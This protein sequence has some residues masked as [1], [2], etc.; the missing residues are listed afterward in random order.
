MPPLTNWI[1]SRLERINPLPSAHFSPCLQPACRLAKPARNSVGGAMLAFALLGIGV[2]SA[3][4]AIP[5]ADLPAG[6]E[7]VIAAAPPLLNHPIMG[8]LDDRGR[9]FVGDAAGLNL[10]DKAL[11]EQLPNRV[12]M[13]E[14]TNGDGVFDKTSVFADK[15]TFPQGACWLNGSLYV[16]SPPGIW[17]LTDTNG[18][19]VA[20]ERKM[21]VSGFKYTG[22]AADVHGPFLHPNGRLYW[23]HGRKG[24]KVTQPDGTLVH[25]GM[26][27]GIWSCKP[28]G[29]DVQWH[30]LA[31]SDN[32]V[33]VDFTPEGDIF[34]VINIYY[35]RPRGDTLVHWLYGG[36]Y[37]RPDQLNVL[38]GL[39]RTVEK[40]PVVHNFGH[41]AVSGCSF[42]RS[43]GLNPA[44]KGDMMVVYFNTQ[45]IVR[46]NLKPS[47][48][49]FTAT[50]HE[51]LKIHDPDVHI[52]DLIEDVDGSILVID[53]GGWFKLG[54]PSS[55]MEKPDIRGAVYRVQKKNPP[56]RDIA[57]LRKAANAAKNSAYQPEFRMADLKDASKPLARLR[58]CEAI[59]RAKRIEPAQRD[60]LL[61]LLGEKVDPALE[62]AAMYAAITTRC[63]DLA[64]LRQAS[65]APL[66]RRLMLIVE[67]TAREIPVQDA[68]FAVA[69]SHVDS[70]D[71]D[72]ASAAA[73]LVARHPRGL[74]LAF[75]D[76][77][78]QL[79]GPRIT[80]GTLGAIVAV[81]ASNLK[82]EPAQELIAAMLKHGSPG[83]RRAAWQVIAEQSG[84]VSSEAW[85]APLDRS[86][87][88]A[89]ASAPAG[90]SA[91]TPGDLP[92]L[93]DA[94]AQLNT[95]HFDASHRAI[96]NDKTRPQPIRLKALAAVSRQGEALAPD[97]FALLLQLLQAEGSPTARVD[98]AR[99]LARAALSREQ[100]AALAPALQTAGPTEV[101]TLLP[102]ARTKR[103]D[104]ATGRL[105][106]EN[107]A[108]SPN[109]G[110]IE[111]S[112]IRTV[113]SSMP[114]ELYEQILRPAVRAAAEVNDA[115]KRQLEVLAAAV[116]RGRVSEGRKV[117]ETSTCVACHK[118]G[119]LGRA[120]GPDLSRIGQIRQPR[121]ILESILF[122][123]ATLARDF[124]AHVV[125]MAD[126]QS[127][128]GMI[129]NDG[130]D[131]L[132]LM[133]LAGQ[134]KTIPRAQIV[135]VTALAESVMPAGL[136][137]TLTE[138]Q[139]LDVV[140]WLVSLR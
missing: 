7:L 46:M 127:Q 89:S 57:A 83:I 92:L 16:A 132:V 64:T 28:D 106:A 80:P 10:N 38:A 94:I 56:R 71:R 112:A 30:A 40:M 60:A 29:S 109:L 93:L 138:Q 129:K 59:S 97:A 50:E 70:A 43:D 21:I 24:H 101:R 54:C 52:T 104:P 73:A 76:F 19:G 136:E 72:L 61:A 103:S 33:E 126:G 100:V 110:S 35:N 113:F 20:D 8:S 9:L 17:K 67:Q 115:K 37:E 26:A 4:A 55:I 23:C 124:E 88:E 77:K 68:L 84:H 86:L 130:A 48:A 41:V 120:M 6:L 13:L 135:G 99:F 98:A 116:S 119:D 118:V 121:D 27:S 22:N 95:N 44:W 85:L 122:P 45:K 25:E 91:A 5:K 125:E 12:L 75:E 82:K 47:G 105:W 117:Y 69:R 31:C 63:F 128:T 74:E 65:A 137:K 53:T 107:L 18:D 96:I 49:S 79:A 134:E 36:A 34:G 139:L 81:A 42:I 78:T 51:F 111:E 15:M 1:L 114:P 39:P 11:D 108:K 87:A 32:P 123:S 131:G 90:A 133:D 102:L 14:D 66:V 62:H 58:A 2:S 3:Q 140:A